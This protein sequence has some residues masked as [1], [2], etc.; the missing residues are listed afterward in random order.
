MSND[1]AFKP[2]DFLGSTNITSNHV[3]KAFR[4]YLKDDA[5]NLVKVEGETIAAG[6]GFTSFIMRLNLTWNEEDKKKHSDLPKSVILKALSKE[7]LEKLFDNFKLDDDNAGGARHEFTHMITMGHKTECYLYELF[8]KEKAPPVPIPRAYAT[9]IGDD[10]V[11]PPMILLEDLGDRARVLGD[12]SL[13]LNYQQLLSIAEAQANLHAWSLTGE[14]KG[15]KE[16]L[17][18]F[19]DRLA[20]FKSFMA[21]MIGMVEKAKQTFPEEFG[22]LDSTKLMALFEPEAMLKY[23]TSHRPYM[24]DILVHG[25]FWANNIMFTKLPDGSMGDDVAVFIDW[26]LSFVGHPMTDFG[27]VFSMSCDSDIREAHLDAVIKHYYA[28]LSKKLGKD[29]PEQ[30]TLEKVL[31]MAHEHTA[32]NCMMMFFMQDTMQSLFAPTDSPDAEIKRER[33]LKTTKKGL[34]YAAK[35]LDIMASDK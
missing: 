31:E 6:Q 29:M 33:M 5:I 24:Q 16:K 11:H 2:T 8:A 30:L 17:D 18:K 21:M 15:W 20:L 35:V 13:S 3:Q 32:I 28:C 25:D 23:H 34:E 4:E 14:E 22:K 1:S 26:Q 12:G 27:R 10:G 9:W 19:E 7:A